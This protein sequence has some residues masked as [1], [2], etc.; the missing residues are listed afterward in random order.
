MV[1]LAIPGTLNSAEVWNEISRNSLLLDRLRL[2][3]LAPEG[4]T[5]LM[6]QCAGIVELACEVTLARLED[7]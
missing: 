6:K 2:C 4:D 5:A 1:A 7:A 3:A